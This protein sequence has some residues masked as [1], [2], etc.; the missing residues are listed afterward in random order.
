MKKLINY[1]SWISVL[2]TISTIILTLLTTYQFA[3]IKYFSNY[4]AVQTG[5]CLTMIF[6]AI[7]FWNWDNLD[8]RVA[9]SLIC[10]SI[11][12]GSIFFRLMDVF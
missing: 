8:S 7:R 10:I 5:L 12:A 3:Y 11:A 2:F 9:Y 4:Y 6:W 1:I